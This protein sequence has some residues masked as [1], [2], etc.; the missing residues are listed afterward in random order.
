MKQLQIFE[1][2]IL[3]RHKDYQDGV[4]TEP[5]FAVDYKKF[6]KVS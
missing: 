3:N 1:Q 5:K 6:A 4:D 2:V